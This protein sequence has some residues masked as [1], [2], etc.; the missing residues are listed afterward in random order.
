M[1]GADAQL[2]TSVQLGDL[3]EVSRIGLGGNRFCGPGAFGRSSCPERCAATLRAAIDSGVS[4]VDT[5]DSYGPGWSETIIGRTLW[6]SLARPVVATKV[7]LLR[8]NA[9]NWIVDVS[10]GH[11]RRAAE[12]SARRLRVEAIDLLQLHT[13]G[14]GVPIEDSVGVLQDLRRAGLVRQVGVCNVSVRQLAA[15]LSAG[16]IASV[17]NRLNLITI[18][19]AE[20]KVVSMCAEAGIPYLAYQPLGDGA[21]LGAGRI[22]A[23]AAELSVTPAQL[24]VRVLLRLSDSIVAI[25]GTCDPGHART[26]AASLTA[27]LDDRD[28]DIAVRCLARHRRQQKQEGNEHAAV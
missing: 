8:D 24:V 5:A 25:P 19:A 22:R 4:L 13:P 20:M 21:L 3:G 15:A 16:P 2:R 12:A 6:N 14:D 23:V 7:G 17:Q 11:L 1:R 18:D 28:K 27:R 9:G 10:P 26:N